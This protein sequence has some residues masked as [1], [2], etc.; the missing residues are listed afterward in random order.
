MFL[1]QDWKA[2]R[3]NVKGRFVMFCFRF[4][5][6]LRTNKVL[7]ILSL[8]Y[9]IAH[10]VFFDWFMNID[11]PI[12][13][14][15]GKSC[16]IYHGHGLVINADTIIGDHCV[17]RH[18]TTIGNKMKSDGSYSGSPVIG[19]NCDIGAHVILLGE[20]RVGDNVTI[21]AGSVIT[22]DIPSNAIAYGNPFKIKM[23][24]L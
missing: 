8:P 21:G 16:T 10:K 23:K 7:L 13:V 22:K 17:I 4:A 24:E 20:V 1:F 9:L 11:I 18:T 19:N 14:K 5:H 2:N 15:I 6:F 12:K 3:G